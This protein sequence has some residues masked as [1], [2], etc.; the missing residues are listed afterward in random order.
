MFVSPE[1]SIVSCLA[2]VI[3]TIQTYDLKSRIDK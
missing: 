3:N 1:F 2:C